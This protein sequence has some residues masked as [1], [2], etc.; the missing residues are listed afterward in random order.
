[1][2]TLTITTTTTTTHAR[3]SF[4]KTVPSA[5]PP[6]TKAFPRWHT[7]AWPCLATRTS[8]CRETRKQSTASVGRDTRAQVNRCNKIERNAYILAKLRQQIRV[9]YFL[10]FS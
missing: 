5:T 4:M 2:A 1:M 8:V 6:N 9:H 7:A 10:F 3:Q